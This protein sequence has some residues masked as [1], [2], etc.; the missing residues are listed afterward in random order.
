MIKKTAL[1][2][3]EINQKHLSIHSMP[4]DQCTFVRM[5]FFII[6]LKTA[7]DFAKPH[8]TYTWNLETQIP[9]LLRYE[10][11]V[12]KNKWKKRNKEKK[13]SQISQIISSQIRIQFT[14]H[15]LC[16]LCVLMRLYNFFLNFIVHQYFFPQ[17]NKYA[18]Y[19]KVNGHLE[20][21]KKV[22]YINMG[23]KMNKNL[24]RDTKKKKP[25]ILKSTSHYFT[26][27]ATQTVKM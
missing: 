27:V 9:P 22:P 1:V 23:A 12:C 20:M 10:C 6:N 21:T 26:W 15:L 4:I 3:N 2:W 7:S 19:I 13:F 17:E 14:T 16:M 8:L 24:K 25:T 5:F 18:I 11:S